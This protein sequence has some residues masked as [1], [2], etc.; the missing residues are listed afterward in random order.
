MQHKNIMDQLNIHEP[1]TQ[2]QKP[3]V[4][5]DPS[6]DEKIEHA[7]E[8]AEQLEACSMKKTAEKNQE[9]EPLCEEIEQLKGQLLRAAAEI[10]NTQAR[11]EREIHH[12]HQFALERFAKEL[13]LVVDNLERALENA[14]EDDSHI[15]GVA[16][17]LKL[18]LSTLAKFG[19]EQIS[20]LQ[21]SFNPEFH[22]A[23]SSQVRTDVET[24]TIIQVLAKGYLLNGSL[25][26][27]AKVIIA[28]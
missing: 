12:A 21:E 13:I 3:L 8:E 25:I 18:F 5:G 17:T 27:P 4:E 9:T 1:A 10:K 22:E 20:P 24:N 28:S 15:K 14:S 7:V 23:V 26:R 6:L 19:I 2:E 11:A 16:L